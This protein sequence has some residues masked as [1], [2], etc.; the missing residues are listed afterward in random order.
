[1][2]LNIFQIEKSKIFVLVVL[3]LKYLIV[4]II[5]YYRFIF[6]SDVQFQKLN[7]QEIYK[8]L[9]LSIIFL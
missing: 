1:M 5:T 8:I 2:P 4:C 3:E 9:K 6:S 7:I